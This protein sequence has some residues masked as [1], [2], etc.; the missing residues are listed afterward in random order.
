VSK[1]EGLRD[2]LEQREKGSFLAGVV[3]QASRGNRRGDNFTVRWSDA[4]RAEVESLRQAV[5]GPRALGPWLVW[6]ARRGIAVSRGQCRS[7]GSAAARQSPAGAAVPTPALVLDLCGGTGAWSEP[8]RKAGYDV[9]LVTLPALDVRTYRAPSGVRGV[10]AAP[11]CS[12]FSGL[13]RGVRDFAK[14]LECVVA[15]LRIVAECN[16]EWWALENP[17]SGLLRRWL[18][19]PRDTWQPCDFG[20][21]WTKLTAIWGRFALPDRN[22]VA[23]LG[24][25]PGE[26]S[27][28]RAVTPRGFADAFFRANP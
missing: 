20:D 18:G 28:E 8:Y 2:L 5:P 14:G 1:N 10:L 9:R 24:G 13:K 12:E 25:M 6:A 27:E 7:S 15:C 3:L 16:P 4:E 21:P 19:P 26:T 23:P 22:Y 17:G 11:P